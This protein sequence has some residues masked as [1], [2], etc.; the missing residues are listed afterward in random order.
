MTQNKMSDY[1]KTGTILAILGG[2]VII[3]GGTLLTFVSTYILPT[4]NYSNLHTPQGLTNASIPSIVS[5]IVG[6]MGLFGLV[7]GSIV[8][9]SAVMLLTRPS[10]HRT[11][12]VLILVFSVL[13][14]LG[15]GGFVLGA[16]LGIVGGIFTLR[17]NPPTQ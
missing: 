5:G 9:A 6:I 12:G 8:L 15:L 16:I 7:S 2:V 14:F 1:P 4:L 3:L 13:S 17:W 10:Q 11:W